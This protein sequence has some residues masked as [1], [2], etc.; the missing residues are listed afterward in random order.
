M[1]NQWHV[2]AAILLLSVG[3]GGK[4]G[5]SGGTEVFRFDALDD[6]EKAAYMGSDV[7][8]TMSAVFQGYDSEAHADFS[9]ASCHVN[10]SVDGTFAMPDAGLPPLSED[11]FPYESDVGLFMENEVLPTMRDL[12]GPQDGG[13][14]CTTCHT[15]TEGR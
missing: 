15:L 9:C 14:G 4:E 13:R 12:L 10:G 7:L 8:P 11:A 6:G 5:D 3:C 2:C 1:R